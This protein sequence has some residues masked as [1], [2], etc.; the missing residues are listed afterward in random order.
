MNYR[1]EIDGLRA[2]AV[3][4]VVLFHAGLPLHG[5]Y[6]GVDVF[7][8]ISGY[9]ITYLIFKDIQE[10]KFSFRVFYERRARRILPALFVMVFA[11]IYFAWIWLTPKELLSFADSL[12]A[13]PLYISNIVFWLQVDYFDVAAESKPLI[14]TWSLAVEEQF[15]LVFPLFFLLAWRFQ[16]QN[17]L[18]IVLFIFAC[19]FGLSV[20][21]ASAFPTTAYFLP[22]TR[23]WELLI[24]TLC[25]LWVSRNSGFVLPKWL[26][27]VG[28]ALILSS[29][30][31]YNTSTPFPSYYALVPTL[32][33]ALVIL[34]CRPGSLAYPLLT[35]KPL[36]F[37][38][39]ISY[40]LYLW[41]Q[42]LLA[43]ARHRISDD[44]GFLTTSSLIAG[45][46][47]LAWIS[48]RWVERPFRRGNSISTPVLWAS[49][50]SVSLIL[51]S[52]GYALKIDKGH[53]GRRTANGQSFKQLQSRIR[54]NRGLHTLCSKGFNERPECR[55]SSNVDTLI[56]GDSFAMHVVPALSV[57][58]GGSGVA[59]QT[60]TS[61]APLIGLA[62]WPK[63]WS[64]SDVE[65]CI[66]H[67]DSVLDWV[68]SQPKIDV[69]ILASNWAVLFQQ[70]RDREL[71]EQKNTNG[72]LALNNLLKLAEKIR[73]M[74]KHPILVDRTPGSGAN[75]GRCVLN[76]VRFGLSSKKCDFAL[77]DNSK[78]KYS[79]R[80]LSLQSELPIFSY[81]PWVCPN[82]R[83]LTSI[84][85]KII[86]RDGGH[87]S[88]E[89]A[90]W[91][92]L[93]AN[94]LQR[95]RSTAKSHPK[96]R[97]DQQL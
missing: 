5:G 78:A 80:L 3:L 46:F 21:G 70:L 53:E 17:I 33:S 97:V 37:V 48:W 34:A 95:L 93:K 94:L 88:V 90:Q 62:Q 22:H 96:E 20:W 8:V 50:L 15:Y 18:K 55:S 16:K 71:V 91:L 12:I 9:L 7:F 25:A 81:E 73:E 84:D 92:G 42:P 40:S 35:F 19:S 44:L 54:T 85:K 49:V 14:H 75:M 23:G 47:L 1:S 51:I 41:H 39:L 83:C 82:E 67:N 28:I 31:F 45:S 69:V 26:D 13:I 64:K 66:E 60:K 36:V 2:L 27:A 58:L 24:G 29:A 59:Q 43:F 61:C 52:V 68:K 57:N 4:I 89:G 11:C 72:E 30:I 63:S 74:G 86:Y 76:A 65:A 87:L 79:K 56:W 38:G 6:V 77:S 32:G 10:D